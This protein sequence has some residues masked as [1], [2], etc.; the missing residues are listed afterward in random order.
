MEIILKFVFCPEVKAFLRQVFNWIDI[1]VI[2]PCYLC[3]IIILIGN[4][5][6]RSSS[7]F[8]FINALRLIRIF[9]IF[10]LTVHVSGLKILG[11]TIKASAKELLLLFLVL[12]IGVLIFAC[13]IYYA[14]QVDEEEINSFSNI[15]RSFWWAVVTMTTLGYGDLYPR[16]ALGYIIGTVCAVSGLLMLSLPVPVIVSNFTLYYTHAQARLK[17]PKKAKKTALLNAANALVDPDTAAET[18]SEED[19]PGTISNFRQTSSG[20]EDSAFEKCKEVSETY[21]SNK[22]KHHLSDIAE[23]RK[24]K[25][26]IHYVPKITAKMVALESVLF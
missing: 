19:Y 10:K 2:I 1:S 15:P 20:S 18:I 26:R 5:D 9:R 3:F 8:R 11:H 24:R 6:T 23:E 14:E 16:T 12:I 13:L 25:R 7:V 17:L 21:C 4:D 22:P